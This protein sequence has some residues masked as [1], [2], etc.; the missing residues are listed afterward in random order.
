LQIKFEARI[1]GY[2]N[3]KNIA[4]IPLESNSPRFIIIT[5]SHAIYVMPVQGIKECNSRAAGLAEHNAML[6]NL[7]QCWASLS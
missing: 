5:N 4:G 6:Q 2:F 3:L 7:R 1:V